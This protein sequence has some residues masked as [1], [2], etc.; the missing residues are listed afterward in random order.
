MWTISRLTYK[1]LAFNIAS[2]TQ[3]QDQIA[4]VVQ[5]ILFTIYLQMDDVYN[6]VKME[7]S[8]NQTLK[9]A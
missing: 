7:F 1:E 3:I 4:Q 9:S 6:H 2:L 8:Q 5:K